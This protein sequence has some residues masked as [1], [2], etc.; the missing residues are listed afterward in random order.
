MVGYRSQIAVEA[1]F[2]R[3]SEIDWNLSQQLSPIRRRRLKDSPPYEQIVDDLKSQMSLVKV[4]RERSRDTPGYFRAVVLLRVRAAALDL[5]YNGASGYRAQY[6]QD[7]NLGAL[8][9]RFALDRLLPTVIAAVTAIDKRTCPPTW[10]EKSLRDRDAKLWP[11][12]GIWLRYARKTD[13]NLLVER[14]L[15]R[16][17]DPDKKLQKRAKRSMLTPDEERLLELK[18]GFLSPTGEALGTFKP[19]RS[20]DIHELGYT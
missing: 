1:N 3:I 20:R 16:R 11:H 8:A 2:I 18:G 10:V 5:F 17:G 13:R 14:W 19:K 6:Y 15:A 7:A 4:A 9:N 12:Q